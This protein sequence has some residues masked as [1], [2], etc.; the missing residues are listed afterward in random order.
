MCG[1]NIY[2]Y[3]PANGLAAYK[4]VD[5]RATTLAAEFNSDKF[6]VTLGENA[7][8]ANAPADVEIYTVSGIKV[9]AEKDIT[10]V[11]TAGLVKGVFLA[12]FKSEIG[13][14]IIKF[15]K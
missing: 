9:A 5:N 8:F 10:R 15:V 13:T 14:K 3:I 4:L 11:S 2:F 12:K 1:A 6:A 7:L